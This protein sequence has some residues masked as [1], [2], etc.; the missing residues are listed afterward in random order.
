MMQSKLNDLHSEASPSSSRLVGG[1]FTCQGKC[2]TRWNYQNDIYQC[3]Y[4]D[5]L[6][7]CFPC[8]DKL[9][10]SGDKDPANIAVCNS[11][12]KWVKIPR[13]GAA[14]YRGLRGKTV[15]VSG[16]VVEAGSGSNVF[17]VREDGE[18]VI[19][20]GAW[21]EKLSAEWGFSLS[22]IMREMPADDLPDAS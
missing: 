22:D 5:N 7:L 8:L 15:N 6:G 18:E 2:D 3:L 9:R 20:V 16:K 4:C 1:W 12:H 13:W 14:V 21:K 10:N 19:S 17:E 11:R